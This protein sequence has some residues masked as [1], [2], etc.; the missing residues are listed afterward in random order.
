MVTAGRRLYIL[1][2]EEL[3]T[4][5]VLPNVDYRFTECRQC[6][7]SGTDR[8]IPV[9]TNKML[10]KYW[11]FKKNKEYDI[12]LTSVHC[13]D[14]VHWRCK[15][16]GLTWEATIRGMH[17]SFQGCQRCNNPE[18]FISSYPELI[19]S[20]D[21]IFEPQENSGID[22]SSLR[23]NTKK[24]VHFHCKNCGHQWDGDFGNRIRKTEDS[25]YR[26]LSCPMCDNNCKRAL[27]YSNSI[28][29]S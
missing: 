1:E 13:T 3:K 5:I 4:A 23:V 15:E 11:D 14:T 28:L 21:K 29:S 25:A 7:L 22:I 17:Q 10:V 9:T 2:F 20:F 16:C 12:N 6:Y 27:T 8:I 19:K 26:V 18:Y 24:D